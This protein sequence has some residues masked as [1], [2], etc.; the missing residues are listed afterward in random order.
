VV[1]SRR[2]LTL[3]VE[4]TAS[5]LGISRTLPYELVRRGKLPHLRLGSRIVVPRQELEA[6]VDGTDRSA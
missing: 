3:T 5:L 2:K 1:E 4:E 6:L